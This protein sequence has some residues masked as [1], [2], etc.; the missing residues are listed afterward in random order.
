MKK[1][2]IWSSF[3]KFS[4]VVMVLAALITIYIQLFPNKPKLVAEC[5]YSENYE[6]PPDIIQR[7]IKLNGILSTDTLGVLIERYKA[8][9]TIELDSKVDFVYYLRDYLNQDKYSLFWSRNKYSGQ[10]HFKIRNDGDISSK[11]IKFYIPAKGIALI[12]YNNDITQVRNFNQAIEI[13]EL[14]PEQEIDLFVWT[15]Y[16]LFKYEDYSISDKD[17]K[18]SVSFYTKSYGFIKIIA[19][20][21]IGWILL[22]IILGLSIFGIGVSTGEKFNRSLSNKTEDS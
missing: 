4:A 2:D 3:G 10:A 17:G 7:I 21:F 15:S 19:D 22:L 18:G 12:S 8:K 16:K 11:E 9:G 6:L 5:I 20:Y 14:R 13:N 1:K